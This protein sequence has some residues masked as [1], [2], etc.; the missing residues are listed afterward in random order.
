MSLAFHTMKANDPIAQRLAQARRLAESGYGAED[1]VVACHV[2]H[3]TAKNYVL[4][5]EYARLS[6]VKDA[7]P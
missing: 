1:I 7:A 5:A 3:D 4:E 2:S 6:Q